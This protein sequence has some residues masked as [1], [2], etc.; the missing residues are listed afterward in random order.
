MERLLL[1][2]LFGRMCVCV[3]IVFSWISRN[4]AFLQAISRDFTATFNRR[5][6][7][8]ANAYSLD[9]QFRPS[10]QSTMHYYNTHH[11]ELSRDVQINALLAKVED[12]KT[13]MGRNIALLLEREGKLDR[14]LDKSEQ[15]KI[16]SMVFKKRAKQVKRY[17]T[18]KSCEMWC[19]IFGTILVIIYTIVTARCG[20][21]MQRCVT[22]GSGNGYSNGNGNGSA[23][24]GGNQTGNA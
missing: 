19:L 8:K 12:M 16:E 11:T 21:S 1:G 2:L 17:Y 15:M 18:N 23:S 14:L 9:K 7:D 3:Y 22:T 24:G 6:I 13:V 10:L 20:I 4:F 5:R